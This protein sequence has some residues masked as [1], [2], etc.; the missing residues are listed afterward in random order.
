MSMRE[1]QL[2]NKKLL[3]RSNFYQ[4][5]KKKRKKERMYNVCIAIELLKFSGLKGLLKTQFKFLNT[6]ECTPCCTHN[7][8]NTT[9]F[10]LGDNL[11]S[12]KVAFFSLL[13]QIKHSVQQLLNSVNSSKQL[14]LLSHLT[15][16]KSETESLNNVFQDRKLLG[17]SR[18][19]SEAG[20]LRAC[21]L[22][23]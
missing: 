18:I 12:Y 17:R 14:S 19:S 5:K 23:Q 2:N 9:C 4:K 20:K 11:L 7:K 6:H 15:D 10:T 22:N 1:R 16:V 3:Y 8:F 13:L 21:I